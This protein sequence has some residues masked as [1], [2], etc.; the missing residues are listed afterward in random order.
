MHFQGMESLSQCTCSHDTGS[1]DSEIFGVVDGDPS[2][3]L[4]LWKFSQGTSENIHGKEI[5]TPCPFHS[6][7]SLP[8]PHKVSSVPNPITRPPTDLCRTLFRSECLARSPPLLPLFSSVSFFRQESRSH[9]LGKSSH[10]TCTQI[11]QNFDWLPP[12]G[13]LDAVPQDRPKP[14]A[15]LQSATPLLSSLLSWKARLEKARLRFQC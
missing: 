5:T 9:S 7:P 3:I 4:L 2:Q 13:W 12:K 1:P 6:E 14:Q 11:A 15:P 8:M 10:D